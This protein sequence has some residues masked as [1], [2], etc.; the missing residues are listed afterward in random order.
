[1]EKIRCAHLIGAANL[2]GWSLA[3]RMQRPRMHATEFVDSYI[4]AWNHCDPKGVADHLTADGIYCD[5]PENLQRSHDEL[6]TYL[7][8]F[9][10]KNRNKY[11][12]IGDILTGKDTIAFQY[13]IRVP[14]NTSNGASPI[15]SSGA[16]FVKLHGDA[17]A[18]ITDYYDIP[19]VAQTTTLARVTSADAPR[20]KYAKS[21]LSAEQLLEYKNRLEHI[22]ESQRA[23]LRSDLTLPRLAKAVN[24]SAN[25]LSQVINVGFGMSFFDYLNQLRIEHA[26]ELLTRPG[27]RSGAILNIAFT[28]GFNSKFSVLRCFQKVGRPDTCLLPSKTATLDLPTTAATRRAVANRHKFHPSRP[29]NRRTGEIRRGSRRRHQRCP[30]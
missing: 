30:K 15:S 21:G 26:K 20:H 2:V 27:S 18:T 4:D 28:V 9:F 24:C 7:N 12:L 29:L 16:E 14:G 5:I 10:A 6:I 23:F 13:Q 22:M 3:T 8:D 11:E 1:M 19:G 25:H 17:A